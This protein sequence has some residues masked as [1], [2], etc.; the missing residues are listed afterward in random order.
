MKLSEK[1]FKMQLLLI[2]V[3]LPEL[4]A[5]FSHFEMVTQCYI[6]SLIHLVRI[7]VMHHPFIVFN[8]N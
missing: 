6:K 4:D 1:E 5:H 2:I 3:I 8:L 7:S